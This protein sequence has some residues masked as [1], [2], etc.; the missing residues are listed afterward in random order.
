MFV[1]HVLTSRRLSADYRHCGYPDGAYQKIDD[2]IL[3]LVS[4]PRW[5]QRPLRY[6]NP[7]F[8]WKL[9]LP[10]EEAFPFALYPS[11]ERQVHSF[12]EV[13]PLHLAASRASQWQAYVMKPRVSIPYSDFHAVKIRGGGAGTVHHPPTWHSFHHLAKLC[14]VC[15]SACQFQYN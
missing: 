2:T 8:S 5:G 13:L 7:P 15:Y 10:W 11:A 14:V 9:L 12:H 4:D 3:E 6:L 1:G